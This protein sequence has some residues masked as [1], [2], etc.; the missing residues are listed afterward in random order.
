M[1]LG[2]LVTDF[3]K[4]GDKIKDAIL[5]AAGEAPTVVKDAQTLE[6]ALEPVIETL[7]PGSTKTIN[8]I[9]NTANA[10]AQAVEDAGPAASANG[11]SVTL[12]QQEVADWQAVIAAAK[13]AQAAGAIP[14]TAPAK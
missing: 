9:N 8:V 6:T 13:N 3:K 14:A 4:V 10:V 7:A 1:T 11:L 12:N 5:K 2:T